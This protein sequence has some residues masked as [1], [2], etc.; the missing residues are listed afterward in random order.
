M[1]KLSEYR[2]SPT[3]PWWRWPIYFTTH[4]GG[5][6][7]VYTVVFLF[8]VG[9][10][11]MVHWMQ[12]AGVDLWLIWLATAVEILIAGADTILYA[13]FLLRVSI[14]AMKE[15]WYDDDI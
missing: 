1:G 7:A 13:T 5:G 3:H 4:I 11:L 10:N 6:S 2:D 12:R 14:K 9:L 15:I 8:A